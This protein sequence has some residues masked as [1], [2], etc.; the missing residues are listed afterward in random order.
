[1][2]SVI[3][4]ELPVKDMSRAQEF[5]AR[6]FGW[7]TS[8]FDPNNV[9]VN[10]TESDTNGRPTRIGAINGS[11]RLAQD[12]TP[13]VVIEVADIKK[14][15]EIIERNGGHLVDEPTEIPN[16][17]YFARFRDTEGNLV[18]LWQTSPLMQQS[19][20]QHAQILR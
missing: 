10:T 14:Q 18:S 13:T 8:N 12:A 20:S 15:L 9:L 16:I 11:F 6:A 4:F 7:I 1:M 5:Y 19:I 17:G 3:H 2:N